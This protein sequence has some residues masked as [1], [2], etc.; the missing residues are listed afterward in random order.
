MKYG[1]MTYSVVVSWHPEDKYFI[2]YSP[3]FGRTVSCTGATHQDAVRELMEV[4]LPS[5]IDIYKEEGLVLPSPKLW[6][7]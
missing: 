1:V 5:V 2:A 7:D 6:E 4:V 3:E